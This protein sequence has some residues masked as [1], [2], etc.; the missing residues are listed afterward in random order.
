M[1]AGPRNGRGA[2]LR[3]G[4]ETTNRRCCGGA[5]DDDGADGP[6]SGSGAEHRPGLARQAGDDSAG[7]RRAARARPSAGRGRA[8]RR[9]DVARE[10]GRPQPELRLHPR[11]MH[12][13][14]APQ[15]HPGVER[16]SAGCGRFRVSSRRNLHQR[17]AGRR[18]QPHHAA[19][20]ER[21]A[22]GDERRAGFDRR[23][24]LSVG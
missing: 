9:Q 22:G 14:H 23:A 20:A 15:R 17:S 13:R 24:N 1:S 18:N 8:G 16:L 10:G 5:G 11:A 12:A 6:D 3:A 4:I 21:P 2:F 7:D 19:H